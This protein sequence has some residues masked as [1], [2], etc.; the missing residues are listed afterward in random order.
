MV[1]KNANVFVWSCQYWFIYNQFYVSWSIS[2]KADPKNCVEETGW[3]TSWG[4]YVVPYTLLVRKDM[5]VNEHD[6]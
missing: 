4:V 2:S 6:T 5:D 1:Y 3:M